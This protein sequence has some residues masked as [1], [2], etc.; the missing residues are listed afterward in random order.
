METAHRNVKI[1]IRTLGG[2]AFLIDDREIV[3]LL[4][5]PVRAALLAYLAVEREA[6]REKVMGVLWPEQD[7]ESAR[8]TLSQTLYR[9]RQTFGPDWIEMDGERLRVTAAVEADAHVFRRAVEAGELERALEVYGGALLDGWYLADTPPFEEWVEGERRAMQRLYGRASRDRI[10]QL[11]KA[12]DLPGAL[13][14]ARRWAELDP[15]EDEAQH[16]LIELLAQYGDRDGALGQYATYRARLAR[17]D[18]EPLEPTVKLV[19]AIRRG[20]ALGA[21]GQG[22]A[23]DARSG[24]DDRPEVEEEKAGPT[25]RNAGRVIGTVAAATVIA[26]AIAVWFL[27]VRDEHGPDLVASRVLVLPL[28]NQTGDPSLDPIGRLAAD[29]ITRGLADTDFLQVA[30]VGEFGG[31]E[32]GEEEEAREGEALARGIAMAE[33]NGAGTLVWGTYYRQGPGLEFHVQMTDVADRELL[34]AVGPIRSSGRDPMEAVDVLRQRVMVNLAV[35]LDASLASTLSEATLPPSYDAYLEY[36][37]GWK[38]V[39]HGRWGDAIPHMRRAHELSPEFVAPLIFEGFG[40]LNTGQPARAD[41]VARIAYAARETLT[42][43]D[44]LR[45]D[46]LRAYIRGDQ[47]GAYNAASEAARILPG[48]SA[49]YVA[50]QQA[51]ALNRPREALGILATFDPERERIRLWSPYWQVVTA[52]HHVLGEHEEELRQARRGRRIIPRSLATL[53][54]EVRALAALGRVDEV[55]RRMEEAL[56]YGPPQRA[57]LPADIMQVAALELRAHGYDAAADKA[58][59]RGLDWCAAEP[60]EWATGASRRSLCGRLSYYAEEWTEAAEIFAALASE[61]PDE[62]AYGGYLAAVVLQSGDSMNARQQADSLARIERPYLRGDHTLWRAR[63]YALLGEREEAVNSL[64]S[65]FA[66][67]TQYGAYL[68]A[69]PHFAS[70]RDYPPFQ[71]I[72]RP[73]G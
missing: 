50:G 56:N 4:D 62:I 31:G 18:L 68:H 7:P 23:S 66:Q 65:A 12:G 72:L 11:R 10:A 30:A 33:E 16:N 67:G 45:L 22:L 38:A 69:D 36:I 14:C 41:S 61:Y 29:W 60:G 46:L 73:K 2:L 1:R 19:D 37:E 54:Y 3:E 53:A 49:H 40:H 15:G 20:E 6:T 9:L 57:L 28:E 24:R 27:I 58:L 32:V 63:I 39:A 34:E 26:L 51:L 44:R 13:G 70:L 59:R 43:Y 52:A 17:D 35:R 64:R 47:V 25:R 55:A 71:E 42:N 48:G 5:Q 8:H 21:P